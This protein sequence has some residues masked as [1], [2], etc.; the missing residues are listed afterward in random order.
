MEEACGN[1]TSSIRKEDH[2]ELRSPQRADA[3]I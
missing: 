2:I 3:W 1:P